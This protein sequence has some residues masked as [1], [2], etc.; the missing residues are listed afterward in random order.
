MCHK[1]HGC[2]KVITS[3]TFLYICYIILNLYLKTLFPYHLFALHV[4][5]AHS[6]RV[7]GLVQL[8]LKSGTAKYLIEDYAA[9]LESRLEESGTLENTKDDTGVLIMQVVFLLF[10]YWQLYLFINNLINVHLS[11]YGFNF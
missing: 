1:N 6:S 9:C 8:L 11:I 10:H 3:F 7:V 5:I 2:I 4:S